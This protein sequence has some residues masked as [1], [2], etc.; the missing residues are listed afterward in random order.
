MSARS[1]ARHAGQEYAD[2]MWA[3]TQAADDA[4]ERLMPAGCDMQ[5]RH[6]TRQF[7]PGVE[8]PPNKPL[9]PIWLAL[10]AGA[11]GL[12]GAVGFAVLVVAP[13]LASKVLA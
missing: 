10:L 7:W 13:W 5:G 9:L 6:R 11:W 1:D 8:D 2:T 3:V 12:V 4:R